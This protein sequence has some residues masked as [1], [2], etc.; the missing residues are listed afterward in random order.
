METLDLEWEKKLI[1][2]LF[3]VLFFCGTLIS[4]ADKPNVIVIITD[5]QGY[6]DFGVTGNHLVK[7]PHIDA[8]AKKS[9]EFTRFYV[10]AVCSPTRA[11]LMTG[12]QSYRTGVTDTWVGRSTMMTEE[13]TIAEV[14]K[15]AGYG[16]G[17]F[18]KWHLGDNYPYRP[19]DQGFDKAIYHQGGGLGQPADPKE[20]ERRYTD[21]ILLDNGKQYKSK[22]FCCDVYFSEA[23]KWISTQKKEDKPF[24]AY[25]A[26]NT[27]HTPLHDVPQKWLEYYKSKDLGKANFKQ[28]KGHPIAGKDKNERTAAIYAMVSNIDDNVGRLFNF[29]N[30]EQLTKDTLVIYMSDNGPDGYRYVGGFKGKK[31][32]NTEGGLRTPIWFH[33]TEKFPAGG[34]NTNMAAHVDLFPTIAELCGA[35]LPKNKKIDGISLLPALKGGDMNKRSSAVIIQSHRGTKP[36]RMNNTAIL[37][38]KWK[39]MS[40]SANKLGLYDLESDPYATKNV[41]AE[42]PEVQHQ[43]L[44]E[45]ENL[46]MEFDDEYPNIWGPKPAFVGTPFEKETF[47]TRQDWRDQ[48]GKRWSV[49]EANGTWYIDVKKAGKYKFQFNLL[50]PIGNVDAKLKIN[51]KVVAAKKFGESAWYNFPVQT[52]KKGPAKIFIDINNGSKVG[53][54]HVK[55]APVK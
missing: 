23:M 4:A 29:L 37:K 11:S 30:K 41:I 35:Q 8:M 22:G 14:L 50:T 42:N 47:L 38:G 24:F 54:W 26:T 33:Y 49:N 48:L 55:I 40:L 43:L 16:T 28:D 52:L 10:N 3:M 13:V 7:T 2:A 44:S 17:L 31:S 5:D 34:K 51:G 15:D 46:L 25:I 21:A 32:L 9:F 18:G 12:R 53:P 1:K 19:M 20:N 36:E 45:Y 39:L 6:G 27:P